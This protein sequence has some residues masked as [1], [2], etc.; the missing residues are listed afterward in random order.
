MTDAF[1]ENYWSSIQAGQVTLALVKPCSRCVI[2]TIEPLT[3]QKQP[4]VYRGLKALNAWGS[5]VFF[6]QN[7]IHRSH[8][9]NHL[10]GSISVGQQVCIHVDENV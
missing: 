6:G 5:E 8:A 7:A 9:P 3:S 10:Q 2:P 4:L 1:V